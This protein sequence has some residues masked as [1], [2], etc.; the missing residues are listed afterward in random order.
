MKTEKFL[1]GFCRQI[2]F[3]NLWLCQSA[4]LAYGCYQTLMLVH[5]HKSILKL[6]FTHVDSKCSCIKF[7]CNDNG[8]FVKVALSNFFLLLSFKTS[9]CN[10]QE[11]RNYEKIFAYIMYILYNV[12]IKINFT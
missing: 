10:D 11:M 5:G 9:Q 1:R 2:A 6:Y 12:F 3:G 8:N 7:S 4:N